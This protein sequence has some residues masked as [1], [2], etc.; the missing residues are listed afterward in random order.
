MALFG[1]RGRQLPGRL[2]LPLPPPLAPSS[3]P[4][5]LPALPPKKLEVAAVTPTK[6]G[7]RSEERCL[8][9]ANGEVNEADEE[10][11]E[12]DAGREVEPGLAAVDED[13]DEEEKPPPLD[14]TLLLLLILPA[15][16]GMAAM[17]SAL[18]RARGIDGRG[19]GD[20]DGIERSDR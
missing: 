4:A 8:Q 12:A 16:V 3:A 17:A 19:D 20:R 15:W 7:R 5:P 14:G 9:A 11:D 1:V 18:G 13:E 6:E 10:L 2:E